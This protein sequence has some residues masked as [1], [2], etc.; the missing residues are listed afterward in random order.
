MKLRHKVSINISQEEHFSFLFL[1]VEVLDRRRK[2]KRFPICRI[3][4]NESHVKN[5]IF[6]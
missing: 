4:A 3:T 2:G 5:M 6:A 1:S